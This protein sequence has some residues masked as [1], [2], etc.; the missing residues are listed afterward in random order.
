VVRDYCAELG[1]PYTEVGFFRSYG[2]VVAYLN[3]VEHSAREPFT[4]PVAGALGRV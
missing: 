3:D 1:V 2:I 4:C